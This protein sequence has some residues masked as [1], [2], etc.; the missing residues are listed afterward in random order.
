MFN[1]LERKEIAEKLLKVVYRLV[2]PILT[3]F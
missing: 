3:R 1:V 2:T